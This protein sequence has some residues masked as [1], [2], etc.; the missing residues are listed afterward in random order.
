MRKRRA[1]ASLIPIVIGLIAGCVYYNTFFNAENYYEEGIE[2]K[3]KAAGDELPRAAEAA[4]DSSI[5]KSLKVIRDYPDSKYVDDAILLMGK[6]L[7]EKGSY[8]E[9]IQTMNSLLDNYPESKLVSRARFY[10][11]RA[12]LEIGENDNAIVQFQLLLDE[13]PDYS[14]ERGV[15]F[16]L[17][18]AQ[19]E[20]ERY[21]TAIENLESFVRD[22]SDRD[23]RD[24][25][26]FLL[27]KCHFHLGNYDVAME[28][29]RR[30]AEQTAS[31]S[32]R[33]ESY[34]WLASSLSKAGDH[35]RA[36]ETID[37]LIGK[38][39]EPEDLMKA[40]EA[41]AEELSLVGRLDEA[42]EEYKK[43]AIGFPET[44]T[45]AKAW[46]HCGL[47]ELETGGD[48]D[49]AKNYFTSAYRGS[50]QSE[51]GQKARQMA[52][53]LTRYS[54]L[55]EILEK[56]DPE[57]EPVALFLKGEFLLLQMEEYE[58][59]LEAYSELVRKYPESEWAPKAAYAIAYIHDEELG[60]SLSADATYRQVI[61]Q[62]EGT[63]YADYARIMLGLDVEP[64]ETSFYGDELADE[65]MIPEYHVREDDLFLFDEVERDTFDAQTGD[66]LTADAD[67]VP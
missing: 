61:E 20:I 48:I 53:E 57:K 25:V 2:E 26:L 44:E 39:L 65:E 55:E 9:S 56:D 28:T 15:S 19:A 30:L 27:A 13:A 58:R 11:G 46:Y 21:E 12:Y 1:L 40:Q 35:E 14:R 67:S 38:N 17:A 7:F 18:R 36:V 63:R 64:K 4:L 24:Q 10:L 5:E 8:Y 50:S 3:E 66:T 22:V 16:Q 49:Q 52:I 62:F 23:L 6:A 31:F 42:L 32:V 33:N 43:L 47:I 37:E 54:R 29:F 59:A 51:Y 34:F 60:D 45:A 41:R